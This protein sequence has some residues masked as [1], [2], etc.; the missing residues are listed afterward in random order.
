LPEL[1]ELFL[2]DT[3][4]RISKMLDAFKA[5][6]PLELEHAAHSMKGS[7]NNLGAK[8]LANACLEVM[9]TCRTGKLPDSS[10]ISKV[11]SEFERLKPALEREKTKP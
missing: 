9:T 1:I 2:A 5:G 4:A 6:D 10:A 3:P 8:S 7:S 11:L